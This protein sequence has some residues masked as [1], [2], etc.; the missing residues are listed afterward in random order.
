MSDFGLND[1]Q[2]HELLFTLKT[3]FGNEFGLNKNLKIQLDKKYRNKKD[4]LRAIMENSSEYYSKYEELY[5]PLKKRSLKNKPI[6]E[7]I[8]SLYNDKEIEILFGDLLSS[9][10][11]M[12][13]NRIFM[14]KSRLNE[15]VVYDLLYR[16]I[17]SKIIR[18][19]KQSV[20]I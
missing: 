3:S 16:F 9:Y 2:K 20:S 12:A 17:D 7:N 14:G 1:N 15:F 13:M 8:I 10:I 4:I 5:T 6:L 11:H 19:K 18:Q